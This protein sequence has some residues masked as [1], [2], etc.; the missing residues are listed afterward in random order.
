[1]ICILNFVHPRKMS[2]INFQQTCL[3]LEEMR[4]FIAL[5]SHINFSWEVLFS[6]VLF[7]QNFHAICIKSRVNS[8][9]WFHSQ[10]KIYLGTITTIVAGKQKLCCAFYRISTKCI[11]SN[12]EL[13]W[14]GSKLVLVAMLKS[15]TDETKQKV[16][17]VNLYT[18]F[19]QKKCRHSGR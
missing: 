1:M 19:R 13:A 11:A 14:C 2:P 4:T 6:Q 5:D 3:K 12:T 9:L 8:I 17:R 15:R 18:H 16:V 7:C 10:E